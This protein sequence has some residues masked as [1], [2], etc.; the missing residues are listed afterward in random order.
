MSLSAQ[1]PGWVSDFP[2]VYRWPNFLSAQ[3]CIKLTQ[4]AKHERSLQARLVNHQ[5][6]YDNEQIRKTRQLLLPSSKKAW[7]SYHLMQIKDDLAAPFGLQLNACQP[8]Q[9]LAYLEGDFFQKH[10]DAFAT[11]TKLSTFRNLTVI[12]F[13]NDPGEY[14]GG[15]LRFYG[16]TED[17]PNQGRAYPAQA[18]QLIAFLPQIYHSVDCVN[19]GERYSLVSWYY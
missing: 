18:G 10:R 8:P 7:L 1:Q 16:L 12:A 5:G 13:I 11:P 2:G 19:Q 6:L 17:W 9:L 3:D 15:Q 4:L 14:S